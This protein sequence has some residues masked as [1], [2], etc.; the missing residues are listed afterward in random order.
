MFKKILVPLDGSINA[1]RSLAWVHAYG[2]AQK[3]TVVLIRI[4]TPGEGGSAAVGDARRYLDEVGLKLADRG[5]AAKVIVRSGSP[6][7]E[8]VE[9]ADHERCDVIV[10]PTRGGSPVKRW[11]VGGVTEQVMRAARTSVLVIRSQ[12]P[13]AA[14]GKVKRILVP[15]DGSKL[16][17]SAL[18]WGEQLA[19]FH[20]STL[21]LFHSA[22]AAGR[23]LENLFDALRQRATYTV[24]RLRQQ[25]LSAQFK[26]RE[27]DPADSLLK[28]A[29]SSDLIV[30]T[31]H[32][33]GG[34]KRWLLGSVA[35]KVIHEAKVPVLIYRGPNLAKAA[36]A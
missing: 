21:E 15:I 11:L 27:G 17:E 5:I 9:T 22:A 30:M 19:R 12:V 35:E 3:A 10:M 4:L 32:G 33:L 23:R 13:V 6:A 16:S 1:E 36:L 34:L 24:R 2:G 26:I 8:I 7:H 28:H 18:A 25:G 29:R 31:T 20:G 14:Q